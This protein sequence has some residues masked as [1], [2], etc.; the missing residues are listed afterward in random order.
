MLLIPIYI[1][2]AGLSFNYYS[3]KS[4]SPNEALETFKKSLRF[5]ANLVF[6]G[7]PPLMNRLLGKDILGISIEKARFQRVLTLI[8]FSLI[9]IPAI[10]RVLVIDNWI[11]KLISAGFIIISAT[12]IFACARFGQSLLRE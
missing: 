11:D 8:V 6:I 2:I 12:T 7:N 9:H 10:M 5:P 3:I 1:S 4:N